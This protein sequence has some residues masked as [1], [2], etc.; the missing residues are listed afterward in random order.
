MEFKRA[1]KLA[2][3]KAQNK[4]G[5]LLAF[6]KLTGLSRQTIYQLKNQSS[7]QGPTWLKLEPFLRPFL[8]L[9][10]CPPCNEADSIT[11]S[12][13]EALEPLEMANKARVLAYALDL[14]KAQQNT[15][16]ENK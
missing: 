7:I 9:E 3:H 1:Q 12:I 11:K 4:A 5:G 13:L 15:G 14:V 8:G 2:L 6:S 16:P 10:D